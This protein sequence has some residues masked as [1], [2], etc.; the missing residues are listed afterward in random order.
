MKDIQLEDDGFPSYTPT[1]INL[2]KMIVVLCGALFILSLT[3]MSIAQI[4][5]AV[6][7]QQRTVDQCV[8]LY[9]GE[10]D[11]NNVPLACRSLFS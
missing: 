11:I 4:A 9:G 1:P 10:K 3:I 8:Y 2:V 7:Q 5:H 6:I